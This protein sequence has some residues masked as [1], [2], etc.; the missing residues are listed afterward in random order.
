MM[1][2]CG[3]YYKRKTCLYVEEMS[4]TF[5]KQYRGQPKIFRYF[6]AK[7]INEVVMLNRRRDS[8]LILLCFSLLNLY[9]CYTVGSARL[10]LPQIYLS[11][12]ITPA[13]YSHENFSRARLHLLNLKKANP[14]L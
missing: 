2:F 10:N 11:V 4:Y 7:S 3:F 9:F 1:S 5:S 13:F 8:N 12:P 14:L 6:S